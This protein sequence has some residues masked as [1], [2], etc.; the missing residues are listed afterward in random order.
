[1][2]VSGGDILLD[3][4]QNMGIEYIFCSPGT[5]WTPVWE[6][7]LKRQA[8][9]DNSLTYINCRHEIL[10][11]SMAMG[12]A[13]VTGKVP[14]VLLHAG[15]GTLHGAMAIR[16]TYIAQFPML[17]VSGETSH[18][19]DDGETRPQG[20]H[21]LEILSDMDGPSSMV[22][23]FVKW[24]N[25]L[26]NRDDIID[27]VCRGYQ[28]ART[29]PRGPVFLSSTVELLRK[30]LPDTR[31][32]RPCTVTIPSAPEA[33]GLEEVAGQLVNS[34]QPVIITSHAGKNPKAVNKITE[35][36]ELL[37]IPVFECTMPFYSSFDK[38]HPLYMGYNAMEALAQADT[39]FIVGSNAPWYPPAAF[40]REGTTVI[41]LDEATLSERLPHWGY[42]IDISLNAD[43]ERSLT[44]LVAIIRADTGMQKKN[45]AL[46]RERLKHWQSKHEELVQGW[47]KEA[48]GEQDNKPISGRWF[49]QVARKV[50]PRNTFY[51]DETISHTR[52]AHQ[53]L[54]HP[55]G[56]VKVGYGGL[57][58][59]LGEA[60]GVKLG[61]RDRPVV[62]M[63]GD[64]AFNYNPVPAGLGMYQEY[65]LPVFVIILNNG[66]YMAM[67]RG[68]QMLY[69]EGWAATH[70]KYL[71]VDITPMPD[72]VKLA[73][74]FGAYGERIKQPAEIEPAL[75][76]GLEQMA[77]GRAALLEVVMY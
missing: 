7:L 64:G 61:Y 18:H 51:L 31:V 47:E 12:Y 71:G 21:W 16:N 29:P 39:I 19:S 24:S 5:E 25:T 11:V 3:S 53:Y 8:Q 42:H 63:I 66:G 69:P 48:A 41:Q 14:A 22:K 68:H 32:T 9:G 73:E 65:R 33:Q 15:V 34:K 36:A 52:F 49:F 56:F 44:A 45:A 58:N 67:K 77:Q 37:S 40:P 62:L 1:M 70:N 54:A 27:S 43:I 23:G 50:L 6:G 30:A 38:G 46:Y 26:K 20:W 13:E 17:I 4:F 59:G 72:Y 74:A 75:N 55:D 57:G 60:A 2:T 28:M 35:L 10:A 76:R